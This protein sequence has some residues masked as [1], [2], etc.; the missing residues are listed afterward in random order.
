MMI[1]TENDDFDRGLIDTEHQ[2]KNIC[3]N[4]WW[5]ETTLWI[6][7]RHEMGETQ[8]ECFVLNVAA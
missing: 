3:Y 6:H 8:Q 5:T 1:L 7:E 4:W 2:W